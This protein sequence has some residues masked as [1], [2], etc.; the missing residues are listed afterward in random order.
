MLQVIKKD[1][2][3]IDSG[4]I[5]HQVNCMGVMGAGIARSIKEK[6]PRVYDCYRTNCQVSDRSTLLGQINVVRAEESALCN[7]YVA[8]IYGQL[9]Y[10]RAVKQLYT[11]YLAVDTA[12]ASLSEHL[13]AHI[14]QVYI[15]DKMG[16]GLAGG[17]WGNY[18]SIIE[19]HIPNAIVCKL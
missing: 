6:Y 16:C 8:N 15:P 2:L 5:C 13:K 14:M 12:F 18:S 19:K 4:I 11:N 1:I 9:F 10:G 7:L 17:N 3:T